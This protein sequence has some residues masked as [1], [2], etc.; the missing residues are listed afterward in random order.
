MEQG[1]WQTPVG[2]DAMVH[3]ISHGPLEGPSSRPHACRVEPATALQL[4]WQHD[5]HRSS[6]LTQR[7]MLASRAIYLVLA[8]VLSST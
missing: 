7:A 8:L 2:R 6:G 5:S 1:R 3:Y 4:P